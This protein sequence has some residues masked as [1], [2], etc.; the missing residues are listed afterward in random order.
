MMQLTVLSSSQS[1]AF[2]LLHCE[3]LSSSL[4][5]CFVLQ[6]P[7][8]KRNNDGK[9]QIRA[10]EREKGSVF[11]RERERGKREREIGERTIKRKT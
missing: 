4:W 1:F 6:G 10:G 7:V 5:H 2:F 9:L 8:Q 3:K 11:L